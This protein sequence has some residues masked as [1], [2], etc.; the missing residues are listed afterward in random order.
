MDVAKE[1][2][3]RKPDRSTAHPTLAAR[4]VILPSSTGPRLLGHG[5]HAFH[6]SDPDEDS[7]KAA[8]K[9]GEAVDA[10]LASTAGRLPVERVR[11]LSSIWRPSCRPDLPRLG[12]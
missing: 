2:L 12:P 4:W 5:L 6:E 11:R 10:Y 1:Q 7:E 9:M 8:A 3:R